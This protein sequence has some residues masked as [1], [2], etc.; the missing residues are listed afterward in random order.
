MSHIVQWLGDER[1][2]KRLSVGVCVVLDGGA[3]GGGWNLTGGG[4]ESNLPVGPGEV[5]R[6]RHLPSG[7]SLHINGSDTESERVTQ[8]THLSEVGIGV[9]G[10]V[11][12]IM[13][14]KL[15]VSLPWELGNGPLQF[16]RPC[17]STSK[18]SLAP[19]SSLFH[20]VFLSL[21]MCYRLKQTRAFY[22]CSIEHRI[23]PEPLHSIPAPV[24]PLP[25][26]PF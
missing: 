18:L 26:P 21:Y 6:T 14:N 23:P 25:G 20:S 10:C 9:C 11:S 17:C 16:G 5:L 2:L 19:S 22:Q 7:L 3:G 24:P 13:F 4:E 15:S 1:W 12:Q 8:S